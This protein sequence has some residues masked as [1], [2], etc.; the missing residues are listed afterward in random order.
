MPE[1]L[2]LL[3]CWFEWDSFVQSWRETQSLVEAE[4]VDA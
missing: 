1:R 4:G 2:D 3:G